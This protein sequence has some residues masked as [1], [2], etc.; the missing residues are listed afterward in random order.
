MDQ[1]FLRAVQAAIV[2][3]TFAVSPALVQ[4]QDDPSRILFTNCNVFDGVTD[5]LAEGRNVLVEDNLISAIGGE[6]LS[7]EAA[8]VIDC[9]G[10]TLMPGLNESH[11]HLNMQHMV[12][13]YDTFEHRDWQEIG[14][15]AAFTAQ[16]ISDGRLHDRT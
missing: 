8:E 10:R 4:A 6:V 12:G 15:M 2:V 11:V 9:D 5:K 7:G 1:P 13:G 3:V 14:A 16:S